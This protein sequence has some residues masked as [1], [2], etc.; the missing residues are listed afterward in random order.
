[1][2]QG[3]FE[4]SIPGKGTLLNLVKA[5]LKH[6]D[7]LV[8]V[9]KAVTVYRWGELRVSLASLL[10]LESDGRYL[11][12][13]SRHRR[14]GYGPFGGVFKY[15][16]TAVGFLDRVEFKTQERS[17]DQVDDLERDLRG[18]LPASNFPAFMNWFKARHG[19]EEQ[20]CLRRE[21]R[22][23]L[24]E[25]QAPESVVAAVE[26]LSYTLVRRVHEGPIRH[27]NLQEPQFRYLEVYRPAPEAES[28]QVIDALF[29]MAGELPDD[30]L[31]VSASEIKRL[32]AKDGRVIGGH[33]QYLLSS[34]W[35][36]VEPPEITG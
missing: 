18:H 12:V 11:L 34:S 8:P 19:R 13:R 24:S 20:D 15:Y 29:A 14:E 33:A 31:V 2:S 10:R 30:L 26:R 21:M 27:A 35:H 7:H 36:G 23:E 25:I 6:Q 4:V 28:A 17:E 3:D 5:C 16:D 32:R 22:E 9:T 1:M